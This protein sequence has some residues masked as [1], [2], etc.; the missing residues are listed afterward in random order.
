MLSAG[1]IST[2]KLFVSLPP[3]IRFPPSLPSAPLRSVQ[4]HVRLRNYFVGYIEGGA[5]REGWGCGGRLVYAGASMRL[6][7]AH[8][9]QPA[10]PVSLS[11]FRYE[12]ARTDMVVAIAHTDSPDT[13][14]CGREGP[15][16]T[17]CSLQ[18]VVA[19]KVVPQADRG[20]WVGGI[21]CS[22]YMGLA[23]LGSRQLQ[24]PTLPAPSA[25]CHRQHLW[26]ADRQISSS[27]SLVDP[28]YCAG[29]RIPASAAGA[30]VGATSHPQQHVGCTVHCR[31]IKILKR[32]TRSLD[33]A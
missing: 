7:I 22:F 15:A 20:Q 27:H 14:W 18:L 2:S 24:P 25:C 19:C 23:G 1:E 6:Q 9:L 21:A 32:L 4:P 31:P 8:G 16:H 30:A 10:A 17:A 5:G 29:Q 26:L 11:P 33:G 13:T 12:H 28:P 3:T